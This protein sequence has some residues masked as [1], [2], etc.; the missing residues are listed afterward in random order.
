MRPPEQ[1]DCETLDLEGA[2]ARLSWV[3]GASAVTPN[4]LHNF[5]AD[6]FR[7]AQR[8]AKKS[9]AKPI[10]RLDKL[11]GGRGAVA[12]RTANPIIQDAGFSFRF[13]LRP[14][15]EATTPAERERRH[16]RDLRQLVDY[17]VKVHRGTA[18]VS[19]SAPNACAK[20]GRAIA[21]GEPRCPIC[22]QWRTPPR[23]ISARNTATLDTVEPIP[24]ERIP[25]GDPWDAAWGGG[26][27]SSST[28]VIG[29][30]PGAG[31][32]CLLLQLANSIAAVRGRKIFFVNVEMTGGELRIA[33]E[34]LHVALDRIVAFP[35]F[36]AADVE[37]E[38][39]GIPAALILDSVSALVGKDSYAAIEVAKRMKKYATKYA[40]PI[41]LVAHVQKEGDFA[42]L[43]SLQHEVDVLIR[44]DAGEGGLRTLKAIENR[45]GPTH[46]AHYLIMT[47]TGLAPWPPSTA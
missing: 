2:A 31:K 24:V 14:E 39:F 32:S 9:G 15:R 26:I 25:V 41:F 28:T 37:V 40:V 7:A 1:L 29:G 21:P 45:F 47:E 22:G 6:R 19:S 46:A 36:A 13:P 35:N 16:A 17:L 10:V 42:G 20:C 23:K 43:A 3:A 44:L 18:R 4:D 30:K 38:D 12:I 27:V 33:A 8:R 5:C 11:S 34:R